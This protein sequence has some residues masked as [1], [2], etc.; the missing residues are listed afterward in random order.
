MVERKEIA[1]YSQSYAGRTRQVCSTSWCQPGSVSRERLHFVEEKAKVNAGYYMNDLL[2]RL[3][4]DCHDLIGDNLKKVTQEWLGE[5]CPDFID[6]DSW[7]PNSPDQNPMGFRSGPRVGS[8]VREVQRAET[9][10]AESSGAENGSADYL[11]RSA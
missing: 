2:P 1:D 11:E 7:P 9:E 4:E 5:H 8:H 10:T 3:L 6:K